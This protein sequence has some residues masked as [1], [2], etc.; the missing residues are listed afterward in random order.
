ML[1]RLPSFP[2]FNVD[3]SRR[4][5]ALHQRLDLTHRVEGLAF[6]GRRREAA[7][8]RRGHDVGQRGQLGRRHLVGRAAI[9][10]ASSC[11]GRR[12]LCSGPPGPVRESKSLSGRRRADAPASRVL[13]QS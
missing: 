13:D 3:R 7:D 12:I 11:L 4:H 8:M 5:R 6:A 9:F 10:I 2:G 1:A